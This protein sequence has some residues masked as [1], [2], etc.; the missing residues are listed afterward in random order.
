M[1]DP[2]D[3]LTDCYFVVIGCQDSPLLLAAK[4]RSAGP[5]YWE[6]CL[7]SDR[8]H[9]L[10]AMLWYSI[11]KNVCNAC[12]CG[13]VVGEFVKCEVTVLC[14]LDAGSGKHYRTQP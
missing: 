7:L 14:G 11:Q 6:V 4:N 13:S 12:M 8:W 1:A 2:H 9:Q 3:W 5:T 10:F